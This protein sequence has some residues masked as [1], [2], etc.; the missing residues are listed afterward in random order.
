VIFFVCL[1]VYVTIITFCIAKVKS[2][3]PDFIS[4]HSWKTKKWL[5]LGF[6]I[7]LGSLVAAIFKIDW[8]VPIAEWSATFIV[9]FYLNSF[10]EDF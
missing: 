8:G 5:N 7:A 6:L 10:S 9:I 3:N 1:V 2:V 4:D